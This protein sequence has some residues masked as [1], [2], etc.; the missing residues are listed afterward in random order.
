MTGIRAVEH[1]LFRDAF[2][3]LRRG[4]RLKE[5]S[6]K[7]GH[8]ALNLFVVSN[9]TWYVDW[10]WALPLIV[11]TAI[12]HLFGLI[13]IDER[14][15]RVQNDLGEPGRHPVLFVVIVGTT[16]LLATLLHGIEGAIWA[17]AYRLVGA[18]PDFSSAVLYSL[19][20]MTS[21]GH[22]NLALEKHWQLMGALEALNGMM[23]FGLTTAFLVAIIQ[24]VWTLQSRRSP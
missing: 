12:I 22:E 3:P 4:E 6:M 11:L 10:T 19:S 5:V 17:A 2:R 23:L 16:V 1:K 14:V 9:L 15:E 18:L 20:A 21:Y 7:I 13:L 8:A 24:K